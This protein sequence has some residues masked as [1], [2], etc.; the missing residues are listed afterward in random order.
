MLTSTDIGAAIKGRGAAPIIS[1]S[2]AAAARFLGIGKTRLYELLA[3]G[4]ITARRDG[5]R[6]LV[7]YA[8]LVAYL[9]TLPRWKAGD[10][11]PVGG[12]Q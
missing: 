9:D 7:E 8:S 12:A 5:K 11:A 6:T 3:L 1:C 10:A 4:K 2:P